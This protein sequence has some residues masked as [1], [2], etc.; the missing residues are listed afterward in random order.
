MAEVTRRFDNE[1]GDAV[2]V[3]ILNLRAGTVLVE[4]RDAR[5]TA[6]NFITPKEALELHAALGDWLE[7]HRIQ[8]T[9]S[10]QPK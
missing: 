4:M 10:E 1:G 2:T 5:S 7:A 8:K 6:E 9:V 3:R